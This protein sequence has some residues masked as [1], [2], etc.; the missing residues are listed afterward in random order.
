VNKQE[1]A[2]IWVGACVVLWVLWNVRND[3]IFNRAKQNSFMQ[4]IPLA[5]HSL[6]TWSFL[7]SMNKWQEVDFGCNRIELVARDIYNQS[8]WCFDLRL[9]YWCLGIIYSC[10]CYFDDW[11]MYRPFATHVVRLYN[12][13]SFK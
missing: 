10:R 4:V 5:T 3:Y 9:T 13:E 1:R 11:Y 12:S 2:Q 8:S 6:C 7:K